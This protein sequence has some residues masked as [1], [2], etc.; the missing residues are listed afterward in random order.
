MNHDVR[1]PRKEG[2][3]GQKREIIASRI[4]FLSIYVLKVVGYSIG[5]TKK[6]QGEGVLN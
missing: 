4:S 3:I 6:E 2:S 1:L 5:V